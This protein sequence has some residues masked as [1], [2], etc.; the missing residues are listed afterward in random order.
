MTRRARVRIAALALSALLAVV[1]GAIA[2]PRA[3]AADAYPSITGNGSTWSQSAMD[4]WRRDVSGLFGMTVNYTGTGSTA[5]RA[6]FINGSVDFAVTEVPFQASPQ[7]GSPPERPT[8]AYTYVPMVAGGTALMYNLR[9]GGVAYRDLRLSGDVITKIFLGRITRWN[10]PAIVAQNPAL[11]GLDQRITPIVRSDS[12]GPSAQFSGWMSDEYPGLWRTGE[13]T[14]FPVPPNGKAQAGSLGVAG[15]VAQTYGLGA[16]TYVENA[17]AIRSGFPAAKVLNEAGY[18]TAPDADAVAIGLL[19]AAFGPDGVPELRGVYENPDPRAYPIS[20]FSSAIVPTQA[21]GIFTTGKGRSLTAF[22]AYATCD[23][24]QSTR[25]LGYS[26][27]PAQNC[28]PSRSARI[29]RSIPATPSPR[30][31][32]CARRPTRSSPTEGLRP[33]STAMLRCRSISDSPNG[34]S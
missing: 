18:Y 11:V 12:S 21:G 20:G 19:G 27:L 31:A 24:Q 28:R 14:Q 29:R 15:Y 23:G 17:Y 2:V 9:V 32:Y 13:T 7:D 34:S 26:V 10:D 16:I 33:S 3:E 22:L 25:A 30:T 4:R 1:S 5:G 6:D 8:R